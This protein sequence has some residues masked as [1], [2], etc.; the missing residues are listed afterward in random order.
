[1]SRS[2]RRAALSSCA[3]VAVVLA[4]GSAQ[5]TTISF[6]SPAGTL[7]VSQTYG[8]ITAY[9]YTAPTYGRDAGQLSAARLYGKTDGAGETGLGLAYTDDHEINTPTGSQAIVLDVGALTGQD[10]KLGFGSVQTGE[11]WRVGFSSSA[12]LPTNESA[13]SGYVTGTTAYP[14]LTDFGVLDSRYVI[15]EA[16]YAPGYDA[17]NCDTTDSNILLTSLSATSVPEPASM[18]VLAA[19]LLGLGIARRRR[20]G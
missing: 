17:E 7:G 15:I 1:M 13:F 14:T 6:A 12:T 3:A 5:A 10:L 20:A 9:G 19:G 2:L 8:P 4:V 18:T 11:A 16:A